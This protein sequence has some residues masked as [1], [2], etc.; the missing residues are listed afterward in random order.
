MSEH[1]TE[2]E[3]LTRERNLRVIL[4]ELNTPDRGHDDNG[5]CCRRAALAPTQVA[6]EEPA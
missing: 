4:H 3:R 1:W 2:H 5:A 6:T